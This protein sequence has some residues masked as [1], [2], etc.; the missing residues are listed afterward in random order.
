[1]NYV[2]EKKLNLD[3]MSLE[4]M[5]KLFNNYAKSVGA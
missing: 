2:K 3:N 4:D 5:L 1:M